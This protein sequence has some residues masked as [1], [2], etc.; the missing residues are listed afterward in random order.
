MDVL[1]DM[2]GD[3]VLLHQHIYILAYQHI[4]TYL[5]QVFN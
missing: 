2:H 5:W 4:I 1:M 3:F